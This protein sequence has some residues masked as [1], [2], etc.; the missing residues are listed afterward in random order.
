MPIEIFGNIC[1]EANASQFPTSLN[2]AHPNSTKM[3]MQEFSYSH[4]KI[5]LI[6]EFSVSAPVQKLRDT[7]HAWHPEL[8][9]LSGPHR[10]VVARQDRD[11]RFWN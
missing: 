10:N 7:M 3:G 5:L 11:P 9:E 4:R 8:T 2:R 1:R 6:R